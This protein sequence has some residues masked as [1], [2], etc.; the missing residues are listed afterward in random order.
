VTPRSGRRAGGS[1]DAGRARIEALQQSLTEQVE[2]LRSGDEWRALL[3]VASRFH[4]YSANNVM[5]IAEQYQQRFDSGAVSTPSPTYVAGYHTWKALGRQVDKGQK[6]LAILAPAVYY[7]RA[8]RT[9]EGTVRELDKGERATP[10]ETLLRGKRSVRGFKI[11]YVF[12]Y[13]QTSG[14]PLPAMLR[15]EPLAGHAPTGLVDALTNFG[16]DRGFTVTRVESDTLPGA[17]GMTNFTERTIQIRNDLPDAAT[18]STLAHELGH[19]LL[20]D[21]TGDRFDVSLSQRMV[22]VEAESV[23]YIIGAAHGLD[24]SS[25]SM[26]YVARWLGSG[27]ASDVQATAGRV[28]HAAHQLL[29]ALDTPQL[30]DG[31][32]PGVAAALATR[33][34]AI[35][36]ATSS[37]QANRLA[38]H[39]LSDYTAIR[40]K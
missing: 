29:S 34:N 17:D 5:L 16:R 3:D 27:T 9:A 30:G 2:A 19:V 40:E 14:Q 33:H 38:E 7:P 25:D 18:A 1:S 32:P 31:Q 35:D 10:E 12:A 28:V 22:E 6:G 26:P 11:E 20:H 23:A 39:Q 21:P 24:T 8:A 36:T 4:R 13:E 15:P 37:S